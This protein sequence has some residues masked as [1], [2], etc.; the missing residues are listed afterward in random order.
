MDAVSDLDI[1]FTHKD[2]YFEDKLQEAMDSFIAVLFDFGYHQQFERY[3]PDVH[4]IFPK[5]NYSFFRKITLM[6]TPLYLNLIL[7]HLL[8]TLLSIMTSLSPLLRHTSHE[9]SAS[10]LHYQF[11]TSSSVSLFH[12]AAFATVQCFFTL[13]T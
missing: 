1:S 3:D 9:F 4:Y 7:C 12:F 5:S 13:L 8:L 10:P 11:D 2:H 6:I